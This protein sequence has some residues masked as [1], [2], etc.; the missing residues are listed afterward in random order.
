MTTG[1]W[2]PPT[3]NV[4]NIQDRVAKGDPDLGWRGDPDMSVVEGEPCEHDSHGN[5]VAMVVGWDALGE[6]Y[7]AAHVHRSEHPGSWRDVLIRKLVEGDWQLGA[8]HHKRRLNKAILEPAIRRRAEERERIGVFSERLTGALW[9][10]WKPGK[11]S[12]NFGTVG[13]DK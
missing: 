6:P 1:I 10:I 11:N 3:A 4:A 2:L 12:W 9:D 8:E 7:V 5:C 13:G